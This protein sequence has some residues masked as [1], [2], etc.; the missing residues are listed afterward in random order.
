MLATINRRGELKALSRQ[1]S[2]SREKVEALAA[3][4]RE[5]AALRGQ[6]HIAESALAIALDLTGASLAF[7]GLNDDVVDGRHI[8]SRAVN[9]ATRLFD[10]EIDSLLTTA[11]SGANALAVPRGGHGAASVDSFCGLPLV[12]GRRDVGTMGVVNEAG[13][14]AT[15]LAAFEV[16]ANH[17]AAL[18]E[19]ARLS[20]RRQ[21]MVD[22][23]VNV[24]ADLD[25]SEKHRVSTAVDE[26]RKRF[27][28][29]LHDDALQKLTA[30][31]LHLQRVGGSPGPTPVS[32]ARSLLQQAEEALRR[33]LLE[34]RPPALDTPGGFDQT[35]RDRVGMLRSLTG[36]DAEL[37]LDLPDELPYEVTT[38]VFRQVAEALTNVEKHA[39][40]KRV[41]VAVRMLD[42]GIH[43]MV[44]DDGRGFVV[45]ERD[46][47]PGH[48]GLIALNERALLAGGWCKIESE[49]GVGTTVE[50]WFPTAN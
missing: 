42:G 1:E 32:D 12:V 23:L 33:L 47:L 13:F 40:A 48:L 46:Q 8:Y 5:L 38:S 25:R 30:A 20:E 6:A 41:Q 44:A 7:I 34:L 19:I 17:V 26:A 9:P 11:A 18:L 3:G 21:E 35:L 2:G 15:Q 10:D 24:R 14:T 50:F 49:P 22:A 37:E 29:E 16:L 39:G 31:E 43:G 28:D 45:A 27:A 36:I 4:M